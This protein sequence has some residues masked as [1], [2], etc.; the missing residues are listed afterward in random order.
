[1]SI[2]CAEAR[3][4]MQQNKSILLEDVIFF[5]DHHIEK[6]AKKGYSGAHW[7][8]T[9]TSMQAI[10]LSNK[11][12]CKQIINHY[13]AMGFTKVKITP[14]YFDIKWGEEDD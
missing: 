2:D 4:L 12:V 7:D 6:S 8:F 10:F 5:I 3:K 1:M 9:N 14:R 13:K 11:Q